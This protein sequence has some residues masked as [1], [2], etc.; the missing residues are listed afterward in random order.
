MEILFEIKLTQHVNLRLFSALDS[1][2]KADELH[3]NV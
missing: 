2:A 3:G 1:H